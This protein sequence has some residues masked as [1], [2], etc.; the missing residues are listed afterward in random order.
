MFFSNIFFASSFSMSRTMLLINGDNPWNHHYHPFH[1]H[2]FTSLLSLWLS[3][4]LLS[5]LLLLS[6]RLWGSKR[7]RHEFDLFVRYSLKP[8]TNITIITTIQ[9]RHHHRHHHPTS[10]LSLSPPFNNIIIIIIIIKNS[11]FSKKWFHIS[12]KLLNTNRAR[13]M[14]R[15]RAHIT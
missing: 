12:P 15:G 1:H 8:I 2:L 4:S 11:F 6:L 7:G 3:S 13:N 14:I 10:S 9:Q 5:R